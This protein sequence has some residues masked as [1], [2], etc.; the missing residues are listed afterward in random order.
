MGEAQTPDVYSIAAHRGFADAL[1]AGLV[2]R[3]SEAGF[4]LA[5]LTLLVPSSRAARTL[6]E[7]FVRHSGEAGLLMPRMVMVGDLELDEALGNLLDPL[8]ANDI[9]PAVEPTQRWLELANL[10]EEESADDGQ[11]PLPGAARLR[12]ARDM[13]RAMDRLLVEDVSPDQLTGEA[14]LDML[15]DLSVHWKKSLRLFARVELRWRE[16][17]AELGRVDA[18]TR[19]NMLFERAMMKWRE[20]TP[21]HPII[22]AGVT[23]A[24]PALARMLRVIA[25]LPNGAVILPDLDLSMSDEAWDELGRAGASVEPGGEVF[26]KKDALTHPQ[27]HLKL[28]L[29][30]MG[31]NRAEVQQWHRKGE[32]AAPPARTHAISSLFLPPQASQSWISM[33]ADKRRLSGVRLM[34]NATSEEEAQAIA[35][36]VREALEQPEKRIAV[37]SADRSLARRVTQHLERWNIVADDTAG[38][39]LSLT[40]AGRLFGLLSGLASDGLEPAALIAALGHPLIQREDEDARR[41]WL[42]A[43]RQF[44]YELRG[45]SPAPEFEPLRNVADKAKVREWWDGAEAILSPLL[46]TSD[47]ISL[48]D[49]LDILTTAAE[50]LA[51]EAVW[52]REDGRAL[53][54][55]VEDVRLHAR[56]QNTRIAPADLAGVLRDCMDAISVRPPYGGHPRVSIYGLLESRM[57]RADLIICG[58]LN[59][60]TWPQ[61]PGADPLLAP[62]I[63]RALGV[64][65]AEFRI[66][67]SA[68][69]LAGALGAP[70]V[71]LSRAQRDT[72]GPTLASRFWLRVE[73][74]LGEALAEQH[75]ETSIPALMPLLDRAPEKPS[76]SYPR[77]KPK[78][79]E[80]QRQ[81]KISA[82]AL[83]RLLGDPYQFYAREIL[84]LK[85]LDPL[86]ADPF[87]DPALRGTLV[88][89]I[90]DAWHKARTH[91]PNLALVPFAEQQLHEKQV[92]PLFWGLW[93]PRICAALEQ[94]EKWVDDAAKEG[95][96]VVATEV[97][98]EM[99]FE[100]VRVMGKPDRI[101]RLP[102]GTLAIV[103]YKT[104][105][106]PSASQVEAGYALQLGLLGLIADMG[107][108][109]TDKGPLSGDATGFEYWSLAKKTGEF[110]FVDVPMK[111]GRKRSG[112]L[113]EDFLHEHERYLREAISKYIKGTAPFTAKE[114]PDYPGYTD[115]DQL[116]R[117]E[118]WVVGLAS[119]E[120]EQAA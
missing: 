103:D 107:A 88:H 59:E 49:A 71:V 78:P 81:V 45:P 41:A 40:P 79:S 23:S 76:E 16:R 98:G 6:S 43:L 118:E 7:A 113:P 1:V 34:T 14:V 31:I 35:M 33:E 15:G 56:A 20:Q 11:P 17:L 29:E 91:D 52:A 25:D 72:E 84:G 109:E 51:G 47:E 97:W 12:L 10:I 75:R 28:L 86:A 94:F 54:A 106:P 4:G 85:S 3:Y 13:A 80:Q 44:E 117:L 8:G 96:E 21:E 70:E 68:H 32:G 46:G 30:R 63:L 93:R 42:S 83:D 108:F 77:P 38:K 110:G 64:P 95:R 55:M 114:N 39:P 58:G 73:A 27:Y 53:S 50:A 9:P 104:G 24:S 87:G 22:A 112:L 18:A 119:D 111:V 100:G 102:D 37:V 48:A 69:D 57:A 60:G 2:P 90:L 62:G 5:R 120:S 89:D 67:L 36:L 19:R 101:D 116:M 99:M 65:G 26:G 115:Y 92:H 74:L 66:G 61:P 105:S 82:T